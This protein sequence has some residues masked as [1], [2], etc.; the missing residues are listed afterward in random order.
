MSN[1]L[2]ALRPLAWD[3][4]PTIVFAV[5]AG[6][7]VDVTMATACALGVGL[8]ELLI[9]KALGRE[10]AL[11]QWAGMGLALVFGAASILTKDPRFIMAKPTIIYFAIGVVMLKRGWMVRYLPPVAKGMAEDLMVG[12]G[13]VWAGLMFATGIA[14]LVV[15][16]RFTAQWPAFIAVAPLVSKLAL[17]AVQYA[18]LRTVIRARRAAAQLA[19]PQAA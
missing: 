15:A 10:I 1:L 8:A 5:L 18:S 13:Y 6:L 17:F 12:W 7:H 4:L 3:F 2:T 11:L 9:V 14:N 16:T 19:L